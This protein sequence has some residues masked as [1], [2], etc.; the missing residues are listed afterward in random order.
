MNM[1]AARRGFSISAFREGNQRAFHFVFDHYFL[2]ICFFAN[3]L[4]PDRLIA[5]DIAQDIFVR[6]WEKHGDFNCEESIKAFLYI[7]TRNACFNFIRQWERNKKQEASWAFA[8]DEE[9]DHVLNKL[10]V[11]E[12]LREVYA[13]VEELPPVCRRIMYLSYVEGLRN[14]EIAEQMELSIHTVRNQKARG[15]YLLKKRPWGQ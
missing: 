6:L 11:T 1:I 12:V 8:W 14:R 15:L 13:A 9:D 5:E 2:P 3:R 10:T 4:V 7:S